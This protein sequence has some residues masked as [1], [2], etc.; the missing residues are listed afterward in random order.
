MLPSE[1]NSTM[2]TLRE[3]LNNP[4]AKDQAILASLDLLE[5]LLSNISVIAT[6]LETLVIVQDQFARWQMINK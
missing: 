2:N 4:A 3:T 1:I 5:G 6:S